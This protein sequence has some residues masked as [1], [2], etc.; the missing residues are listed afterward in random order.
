MSL[1]LA[2]AIPVFSALMTHLL[3]VMLKH[4]SLVKMCV[5]ERWKH[6]LLVAVLSQEKNVVV[7]QSVLPALS[8]VLMGHA[9]LMDQHA[10]PTTIAIR[11]TLAP[12]VLCAAV[13]MIGQ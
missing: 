8:A 3:A 4:H 11:G 5:V 10:A 2:T 7:V 13:P 12:M 9:R 1:S 6:V